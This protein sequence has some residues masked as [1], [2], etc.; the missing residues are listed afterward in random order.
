MITKT[1]KSGE[2]LS[3]LALKAAKDLHPQPYSCQSNLQLVIS[4]AEFVKLCSNIRQYGD[5]L[6]TIPSTKLEKLASN[7]NRHEERKELKVIYMREVSFAILKEISY[8]QRFGKGLTTIGHFMQ[9]DIELSYEKFRDEFSESQ[10]VLDILLRQGSTLGYPVNKDN[11]SEE[12]NRALHY[13]LAL[14]KYAGMDMSY[15][16]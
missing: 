10:F 13:S 15:A 11:L 12:A 7:Y 2:M 1:V 3:V 5:I 9:G 4:F 8:Q 16:N 14:Y 6:L